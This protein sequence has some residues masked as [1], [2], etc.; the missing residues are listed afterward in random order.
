MNKKQQTQLITQLKANHQ[1]ARRPPML[2]TVSKLESVGNSLMRVYLSGD[3]LLGFPIDSH[4]YHIKVFLPL[5]HQTQPDLPYLEKGKVMW[6]SK[7]N[8]PI[9]RT[10]TVKKF[11]PTTLTLQVEF[12]LHDHPGPACDWVKQCQIG[13]KLG[14]AGPGGPYPILAPADWHI[15]AGD[16]TAIPAIIALIENMPPN[17]HAD[18]FLEVKH[19]QDIQKLNVSECINVTWLVKKNN[20]PSLLIEQTINAIKPEFAE[21]VSA[22]IGGEHSQVV[23][24]RDTLKQ[25]YNLNKSLLYAVPYWANGQNEEQY[26]QARHVV[27][28]EEY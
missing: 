5:P 27:M 11:D 1:P 14:V 7:Q 15:L 23:A 18:V 6:P 16:I 20:Q 17:Q 10:Y 21:S 12:A 13:D 2:L 26:H 8:K 24:I 4:A 25:K 19:K 9:T 3:P 28:D 22:F